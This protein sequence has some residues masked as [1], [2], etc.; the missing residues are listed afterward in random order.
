MELQIDKHDKSKPIEMNQFKM[1]L[2]STERKQVNPEDDIGNMNSSNQRSNQAASRETPQSANAARR[3]AQEQRPTLDA[4]NVKTVRLIKPV[5]KASA[6]PE[7]ADSGIS[8]LPASLMSVWPT[9]M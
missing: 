8:S 9:D 3:K 1:K 2:I 7:D 5:P 6:R 4:I